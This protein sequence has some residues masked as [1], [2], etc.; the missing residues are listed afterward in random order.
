MF[1][2]KWINRPLREAKNLKQAFKCAWY[3]QR[4]LSHYKID[5]DFFLLSLE[6]FSVTTPF[7]QWER[8]FHEV[9]QNP[10]K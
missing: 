9:K 10:N 1:N 7:Y 3:K 4:S 2:S 6:H 5:F 8:M